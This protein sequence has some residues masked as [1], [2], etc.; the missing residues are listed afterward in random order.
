MEALR[1]Q[2]VGAEEGRLA[3]RADRQ[4]GMVDPVVRLDGQ[5]R[6]FPGLHQAVQ[7]HLE[8]QEPAP[9]GGD[10]P[11]VQQHARAVR[12]RVEPQAGA[13][14]LPGRGQRDLPAVFRDPRR[15]PEAG[16]RA[17]VVIG[18]GHRRR[19]PFP[20]SPETEIPYAAQVDRHP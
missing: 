6:G 10:F 16:V 1:F 14:A 17:L 5:L 20:V 11:S 19:L 15:V 3:L 18:R 7:L 13:Q 9:V 2:V 4:G 8:G 12:H